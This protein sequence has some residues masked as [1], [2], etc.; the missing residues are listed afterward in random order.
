MSVLSTLCNVCS[1]YDAT[2]KKGYH[3]FIALKNDKLTVLNYD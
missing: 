2:T 3:D 1:Q